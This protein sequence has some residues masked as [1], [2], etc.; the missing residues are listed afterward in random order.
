MVAAVDER[1]RQLVDLVRRVKRPGEPVT[2]LVSDRAARLPGLFAL[3]ADLPDA[4][5]LALEPGATARG[6]LA[7]RESIESPGEALPFVTRLP[8]SRSPALEGPSHP[9]TSPAAAARSGGGETPT[10]VVHDGSAFRI[11][12]RPLLI[13]LA[14]PEGRRGLR[15]RGDTAGVS[16]AHCT[17]VRRGGTVL[18]EDHS[19]HGTFV[20]GEPVAGSVEVHAGDRLRVGSPG[21]ELHLVAVEDH[22]P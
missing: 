20:N 8:V 1:Y 18:L 22:A 19:G 5:A 12:E 2:L 21:I 7:H 13:G 3:L 16:Q 10:H 6:A 15:L 11:D 17:L 14:I 4:A 9:A